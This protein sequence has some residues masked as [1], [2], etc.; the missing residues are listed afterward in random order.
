MGMMTYKMV[1]SKYFH[2]P[3]EL[4]RKAYWAIKYLNCDYKTAGEKHV[5]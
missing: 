1:Y 2:L 5:G 4:E 3:V